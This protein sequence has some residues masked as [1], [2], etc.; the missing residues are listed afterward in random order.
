MASITK[1]D[2]GEGSRF[3][4]KPGKVPSELKTYNYKPGT[5]ILVKTFVPVQNGK[6]GETIERPKG[7]KGLLK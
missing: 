5:D 1:Q 4:F 3:V 6:L 7:S 2:Y